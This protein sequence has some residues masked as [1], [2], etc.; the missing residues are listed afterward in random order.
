MKKVCFV[1]IFLMIVM[2]GSV[3][4][5]NYGNGQG[6]N[7]ID[8]RISD[9]QLLIYVNDTDNQESFYIVFSRRGKNAFAIA[10]HG[11]GIGYYKDN[12]R[13]SCLGSGY[14]TESIDTTFGTDELSLTGDIHCFS[15]SDELYGSLIIDIHVSSS[16]KKDW[17]SCEVIGGNVY[18]YSHTINNSDIIG[19]I[20]NQ[21]TRISNL[22]T[23]QETQN[24]KISALELWKTTITT[25]ISDILSSIT[26]LV[27]RVGTLESAPTYNGTTSNETGAGTWDNFKSYITSSKR[28]KMV[29]GYAEE[30]RL[31]T[32]SELGY[33]C[34]LTYKTY[35]SGRERVSC[36]CKKI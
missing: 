21:E 24:N 8:F 26:G 35:S 6:D 22:E 31:D 30:N 4:A 9:D 13:Y 12:K 15:D 14:G 25:Q 27:T 5:F 18:V 10:Q 20:D 2:I 36:R 7:F 11:G 28:K 1:F 19:L 23:E 3:S 17:W 34:N 33:N 32:I 29:C 16:C